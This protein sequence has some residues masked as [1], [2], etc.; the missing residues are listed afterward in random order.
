VSRVCLLYLTTSDYPD[1][2]FENSSNSSNSLSK[3]PPKNSPKNQKMLPPDFSKL[4]QFELQ[5]LEETAN[6][7]Q[8]KA[9]MNTLEGIISTCFQDCVQDLTISDLLKEEVTNSN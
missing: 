7:N 3:T 1:D 6:F 4:N 5:K 8:M 2:S 9:V